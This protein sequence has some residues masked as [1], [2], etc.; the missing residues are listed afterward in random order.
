[1]KPKETSDMIKVE[2]ALKRAGLYE[3]VSSLKDGALTYINNI[4]T[5]EGADLSGGEKQK[6]ILARALYKD[7]PVL[8]LDEPTAALDPIAEAALYDE[9]AKMTKNK[10]SVYISHRLSS[11]RFCD[12]IIFVEDGKI[13]ETGTHS[14][15]MKKQGKYAHMFEVQSHYYKKKVEGA[16]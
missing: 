15:L 12:R 8:I 1:M 5:D 6:L 13:A 7:A 14:E 10:T 4:F 9:Y 3:K 2:E 16:L 11:T